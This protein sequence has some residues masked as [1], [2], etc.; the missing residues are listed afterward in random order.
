MCSLEWVRDNI[1][2]FGGDPEKI[3][4]WGNAAGAASIDMLQFGKYASD[5][6]AQGVIA[7]SG[8]ALL[9]TNGA[10]DLEHQSFTY[11]AQQM[12]C[13]TDTAEAEL[14]CMR[15][16]DPY[17][18]ENLLQVHSDT[19]STPS[20]WFNPMADNVTVFTV[21]QYTEMGNAGNFS[22]V[23]SLHESLSPLLLQ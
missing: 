18:V 10:K 8:L 23:A 17:K 6:I 20:L 16:V 5:P 2:A 7:D 14:E 3:V 13:P 9:G 4:L 21:D 1:E 15:T 22:K 12:G 19:N 11:V